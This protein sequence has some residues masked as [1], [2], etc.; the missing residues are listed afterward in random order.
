M[1]ALVFYVSTPK[2]K[3]LLSKISKSFP[4]SSFF[5]TYTL[6]IYI[7]RHLFSMQN[8]KEAYLFM[9]KQWDYG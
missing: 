2:M 4:L 8:L 9:E 5:Q 3:I 6:I 7:N 1:L